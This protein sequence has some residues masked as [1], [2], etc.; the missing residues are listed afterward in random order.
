MLNE[1]NAH[2]VPYTIGR[3]Q[4]RSHLYHQHGFRN[5][6]EFQLFINRSDLPRNTCFAD[7]QNQI[8]EDKLMVKWREESVPNIVVLDDAIPRTTRQEEITRKYT[9]V[10]SCG[11]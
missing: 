1:G 6:S 2:E 10:E 11:T 5:V 8:S 4:F 9:T 7:L 3:S